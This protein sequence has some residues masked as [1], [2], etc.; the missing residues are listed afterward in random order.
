MTQ[1]LYR[2]GRWCVRNRR[3][4]VIVWVVFAVLATVLGKVAGGEA[5][6]KFSVPGVE[7]QKALDVLRQRFPSQSGTSAQ[8]V[9]A[10]KTATLGDASAKTAIAAAVADISTQPSVAGVSPLSVSKNGTI[11]FVPSFGLG[12]IAKPA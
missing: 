8:V 4:V 3:R 9:F 2:L 7:S 10:T 12:S 1:Y 11:G 5:S 6:N